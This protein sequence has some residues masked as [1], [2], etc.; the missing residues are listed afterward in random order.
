[1]EEDFKTDHWYIK[2]LIGIDGGEFTKS[3]IIPI[4]STLRRRKYEAELEEDGVPLD[5][6]V[7]CHRR[8]PIGS[9]R[10]VQ[11][12]SD[13][14]GF[15]TFPVTISGVQHK[16][17]YYILHFWDEVDCV[18]ESK[19]EF[20][21]FKIDDKIRP[22]LAGQYSAFFKLIIDT[23]RTSNKHIFRI[24]RNS[25]KIIVSDEVK[26]QFEKNRITGVEFINVSDC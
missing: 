3:G 2:R 18:D 10:V 6:T 23:S 22:D 5:F 21:K 15:T 25:T 13:F 8:V 4:D 19:S 16:S 11:A 1:M 20:K 14:T 7:T 26:Y 12:L 24:S 9:S 17:S